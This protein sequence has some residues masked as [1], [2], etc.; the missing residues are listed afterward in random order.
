[1]ATDEMFSSHSTGDILV[2]TFRQSHALDAV[3]VDRMSA[4]VKE[5]IK[6][7]PEAKFLFDFQHVPY[8]SSSALGMLIGLHHRIV[9]RQGRLKLAGINPEVMD[10]FRV[11]KLDTVFEIHK[12]AASAI[13]AF[14]QDV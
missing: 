14:R 9:Q 1:M 2:V 8:L 13:E 4:G 11:T 5:L 6:N 12:D 3:A 10:V 7:A